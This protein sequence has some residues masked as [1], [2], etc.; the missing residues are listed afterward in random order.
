[1]SEKLK[2]CKAEVENQLGGKIKRLLTDGGGEY[3]KT[4]EQ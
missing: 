4:F 1:M 2:Q 3:K